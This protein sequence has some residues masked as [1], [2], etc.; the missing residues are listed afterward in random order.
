MKVT[1]YGKLADL[2]G[3][4][5]DLAVTARCTVAAVRSRIAQSHPDAAPT[6]EDRRVRA[7][8]GST[9]VQ[10]DHPLDPYDDVEFLAPVSGG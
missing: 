3:R 10:D 4:E 9:L 7:C 1:F 5:L 6:L 8:V 2:L